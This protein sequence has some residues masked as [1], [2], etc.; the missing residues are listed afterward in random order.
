MI[1]VTETESRLLVARGWENGN[2][3]LLFNEYSCRFAKGEELWIWMVVMGTQ[4]YEY[5]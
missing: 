4:P 2:G 1:L 3:E 5:T